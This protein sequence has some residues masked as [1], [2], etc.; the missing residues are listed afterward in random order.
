MGYRLENKD[1]NLNEK[2]FTRIAQ[3][4]TGNVFKCNGYAIKVFNNYAEDIIDLETAKYLTGIRTNRIILP[5]KLLFYNNCFKGY[6]M[7]LVKKDPKQKKII[8]CPTDE[9][10]RNVEIIEEDIKTLSDKKVLLNGIN[11]EN[12]TFNGK[13]YL[14]DPSK[15][16]ILDI[17]STEELE[18]LNNY[19]FYILLTNLIIKELNKSH[20]SASTIQRMKELL[21]L[22]DDSIYYSDYLEE[23]LEDNSSIKTLIKK[24]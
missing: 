8:N 18:K 15:Y 17:G 21:S 16:R 6:S 13:L 11:P 19:Q 10:I 3:G 23:I 12:T 22:K 7:K 4:K 20:I 5:N 14:T 2:K 9:L 1:I 24:I